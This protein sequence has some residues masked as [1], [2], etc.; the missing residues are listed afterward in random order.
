MKHKDII[1]SFFHNKFTD[2]IGMQFEINGI[3]DFRITFPTSENVIGNSIT[4]IL[5]GGVIASV[6]DITGGFTL[7]VNLC[8]KY[9]E[10][11][12]DVLLEKL[13]KMAT[14]DL[15]VDYLRPGRGGSFTATGKTLRVG[16][17]IAVCSMELHNNGGSFIAAGT[18]T[19]F[20][21]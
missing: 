4:G 12:S 13:S 20:V 6:L 21:G 17:K 5:H 1:E 9:K 14:I 16:N 19:Y 2:L 7:L 3:D 8:E 18:G 15:R 11:P 10:L